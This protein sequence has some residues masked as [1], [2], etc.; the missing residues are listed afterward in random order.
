VRARRSDAVRRAFSART[1]RDRALW[2]SSSEPPKTRYRTARSYA[3]SE[4]S[5]ATSGLRASVAAAAAAA[6]VADA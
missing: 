1:G 2:N 5:F 6:Y 4:T 3:G